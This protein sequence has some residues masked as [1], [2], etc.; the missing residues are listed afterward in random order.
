[1]V[2]LTIFFCMSCK[3]LDE[4][5]PEPQP[6]DRFLI[7]PRGNSYRVVEIGNQVW[8]AENVKSSKTEDDIEIIQFSETTSWI[9]ANKEGIPGFSYYDNKLEMNEKYGK[10]YNIHTLSCCQVCPD[11][12]HISTLSDW[13]QLETILG[14]EAGKKL[15][16]EEGWVAEG[17]V[18]SNE[19]RFSA[20][21]G[22][23][24]L[25]G[26]DFVGA[27]KEVFWWVSEI[28]GEFSVSNFVVSLK[29]GNNNIIYE[30]PIEGNGYYVRCVKD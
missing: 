1:M 29:S 10:I 16:S 20:N 9:K 24:R 13:K 30:R 12:W 18:L 8:F 21:P 5:M 7:T 2:F 17:N 25:A 11:G 19:L 27:G 3:I 26:G 15:K 23:K 4:K 14:A 28:K 22:G 6:K